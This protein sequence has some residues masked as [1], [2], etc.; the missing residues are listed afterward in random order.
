MTFEQ[1]V[2]LYLTVLCLK[3]AAKSFWKYLKTW[4]I[5]CT[6]DDTTTKLSL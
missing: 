4:I 2:F 6:V 5:L 3:A 1:Y